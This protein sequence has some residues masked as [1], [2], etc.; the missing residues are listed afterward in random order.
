MPDLS[1]NTDPKISGSF[2]PDPGGTSSDQEEP[3]TSYPN[4]LGNPGNPVLTPPP[5]SPQILTDTGQTDSSSPIVQTTSGGSNNP[6]PQPDTVVNAP[7]APKKYGGKKV[8]ATIFGVLL[9]IGGVTVGVLLVQ[10]QQLLEQ[11]ASSGDTPPSCPSD[12]QLLFSN[13]GDL[14][15]GDT[16]GSGGSISSMQGSWKVASRNGVLMAESG[17]KITVDFPNSTHLDTALIYDNDPKSGEQPWSIN[18]VSL[19]VTDNNEWGPPFNLNLTATQMVFNNGGDSPHFNICIKPPTITATPTAT[20]PNTPTLTPPPEITAECSAVKA[21]DSEWNLL[22]S[23]DLANLKAGDVVRFTVSGTASS[24]TFDKARFTINGVL[25]AEVTTKKPGSNEFYD[26]YTVPVGVT[27]FNVS[28]QIHHT[29][30][31]WF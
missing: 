12:T 5:S 8:I 6:P 14:H 16:V 1:Q 19:P 20:P 28:A 23:T 26:Q 24:G 30:L 7:H 13:S 27:T 29:D 17:A 3:T 31:G 11:E 9:L 25:R 22:S 4:P 18:G 10:R 2:P 21:Y 15:V